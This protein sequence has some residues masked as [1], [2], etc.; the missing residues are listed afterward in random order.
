MTDPYCHKCAGESP[1]WHAAAVCD[2]CK[3]DLHRLTAEDATAT[4]MAVP[5]YIASR[6]EIYYHGDPTP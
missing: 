4:G 5:D 1:P 3:T 6:R 2:P